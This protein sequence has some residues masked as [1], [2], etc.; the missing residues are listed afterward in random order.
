MI[1]NTSAWLQEV[2]PHWEEKR[3]DTK[4]LLELA[5]EGIP[6]RCR[7]QVWLL[8]L[9]ND[10]NINEELFSIGLD[11]AKVAC[12]L[13]KAK[14]NPDVV[15]SPS[16]EDLSTQYVGL[17]AKQ[18]TIELIS[19]DITITFPSLGIFQKGGPYHEPLRNVLEAYICYRPDVGYVQVEFLFSFLFLSLIL[20]ANILF[21]L[22]LLSCR[23]WL[24]LGPFSY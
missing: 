20:H 9:G 3:K 8:S 22:F 16:S 1:R 7:G 2:I 15:T 13:L 4:R 11:R 19:L 17:L 12:E 23:E 18:E 14:E 6:P 10:L 5:G 24:T 21:F